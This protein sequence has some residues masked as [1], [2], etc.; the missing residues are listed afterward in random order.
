MCTCTHSSKFSL[1]VAVT[2]KASTETNCSVAMKC[3]GLI[4]FPL[5]VQHP[6]SMVPNLWFHPLPWPR[7]KI[8]G[9]RQYVLVEMG[10]GQ[11]LLVGAEVIHYFLYYTVKGGTGI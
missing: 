3:I 2:S 5:N 6:H 11:W 1:E 7:L 8:R 10:L 4:P 9:R